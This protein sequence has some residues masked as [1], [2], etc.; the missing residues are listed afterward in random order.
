MG[1]TNLIVPAIIIGILPAIVGGATCVSC[2]SSI[3]RSQWQVTGFPVQS[4]K[5]ANIT[6]DNK[7]CGSISNSGLLQMDCPDFCVEMLVVAAGEYAVLR[8]CHQYLIG[9][10]KDDFTLNGEDDCFYGGTTEIALVDG[11]VVHNAVE[12]VRF[13]TQDNCN[14][15]LIISTDYARGSKWLEATSGCK[16]LPGHDCL[17]CYRYDNKGDCDRRYDAFCQGAWCTKTIGY[18]ND[19]FVEIRGCANMNPMNN[20]IC[21]RVDTENE[22]SLLGSNSI[23]Q[24]YAVEQCMC[25]GHRCNSATSAQ[26]PEILLLLL[27]A[28]VILA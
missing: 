14:T 22:I 6:F 1:S 19:R 17:S 13:C 12:G 5:G 4:G 11:K 23:L 15:N 9:D 7:D 20:P 10:I 27:L 16:K 25:Q 2:A 18:I 26:L 3:L 24:Q 8:G 28:F 21:V